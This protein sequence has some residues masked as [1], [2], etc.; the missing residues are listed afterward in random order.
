MLNQLK[1]K[2]FQELSKTGQRVP[3]YQS[4]PADMLTPVLVYRTIAENNPDSFLLDSLEGEGDASRYS[5]IGFHPT[6]RLQVKEK[7][8][9]LIDREG[10]VSRQITEDPFAIIRK[11]L[12]TKRTVALPE[13]PSL[14]GGA[15]GYLSYDSVRL[16]EKI[17]DRHQE[18]R[19]EAD[20]SFGFYDTII[21]FDHLRK[22][23]TIT[24]LPDPTLSIEKAYEQAREIISGLISQIISAQP[25]QETSKTSFSEKDIQPDIDDAAFAKMVNQAK[26][27]I[28]AGDAFQIVLSRRFQCSCT[29]RPFDVYRALRMINPSPYMFYLQE[30]ERAI[31]GASPERLVRV[32]DGFVETVP[33]AGTRPRGDKEND[34]D[35]EKELLADPKEMAEHMMLVDLA[36]NDLGRICLPG[37]IEV[38]ELHSIQKLSHVMHLYSRV[39]G[40]MNPSFDVLDA[41]Q[42][43]L[44]AG[45]L[46]GAPKIRAMEIIDE[47]ETSPRGLYGGSILYLDNRGNMDSCIAIRMAVMEKGIATVRAGAGIVYDSDP[48]KEAAETR[49]KAAALLKAIEMA[50]RG[51]LCYS[52]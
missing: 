19:Q 29:A 21:A 5:F 38:K 30:G 34:S 8:L 12:E 18:N 25:P 47:L 35:L 9:S 7:E 2:D 32:K 26:E 37:S 16:F 20:L 40:K 52:S 50:E 3:V 42:S 51:E 39:S 23:A 36:R 15:L 17:P 43:V 4:I 24:H 46:S 33:I 31:V 48:E 45:T 27:Y 22:I 28:K 10:K 41:I 44:P 14:I 13:L 1:F 11:I 6:L 49:H